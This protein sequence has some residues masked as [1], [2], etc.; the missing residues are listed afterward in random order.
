METCHDSTD[1][2][3]Y[4]L[5]VDMFFIY[6]LDTCHYCHRVLAV[7]TNGC[8]TAISPDHI[9]LRWQA[10]FGVYLETPVTYKST[11][12]SYQPIS[13]F[14]SLIKWYR[15]PRNPIDADGLKL[16]SPTCWIAGIS[17]KSL[18]HIVFPIWRLDCIARWKRGAL[19]SSGK[20]MTTST[21]LT[22]R[23]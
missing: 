13:P 23:Q 5:N 17:Q 20:I 21:T 2:T 3:M 1:N 19:L 8:A 18:L 22:S 12:W 11:I 15:A 6:Y 7:R 14:R 4:Q 10:I 16:V 9:L